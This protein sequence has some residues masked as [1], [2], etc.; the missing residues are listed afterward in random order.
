MSETDSENDALTSPDHLISSALGRRLAAELHVEE[1][2]VEVEMTTTFDPEWFLA[3]FS[4]EVDF[5]TGVVLSGRVTEDITNAVKWRNHEESEFQW[6]GSSYPERIV[7]LLRGDPAKRGSMENLAPV[8]MG[9][10]RKEI[11]NILLENEPFKSVVPAGRVW[12]VLG[13]ELGEKFDI[14]SI[15]SYAVAVSQ[16]EGQ[17]AVE[18]LGTELHRLQLLPD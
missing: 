16:Q 17:A 9:S 12:E 6:D 15:A 1:L 3:E 13:G 11:A 8:S 14:R 2:G 4:T 10:L 7:V 5:D 18:A